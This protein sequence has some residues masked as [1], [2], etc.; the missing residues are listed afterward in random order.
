[1]ASGEAASGQAEGTRSSQKVLL[2]NKAGLHARAATAFVLEARKFASTIEVQL[3]GRVVDGKSVMEM[4]TLAAES[5]TE[6]E[7]CAKGPD[8]RHA[9]DALVALV[10]R[11]FGEES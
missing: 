8:A 5:G 11:R 10:K 9:L 1:M 4:L 3:D 7:I 6:I 2:T